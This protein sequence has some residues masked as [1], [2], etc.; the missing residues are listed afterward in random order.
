MNIDN[1]KIHLRI[2]TFNIHNGI[3]WNGKYDPEGIADFIKEVKPDLGGI[4]EVSCWWSPKTRFQNME[5]FFSK[6]LGMYTHFSATIMKSSKGH[7]GNMVISSHPCVNVWTERLPG[8][9][10]P[11]NFIAVQVQ[12]N[13]IRINFLTT[14]LGLTG[15]E[16]L[17]QIEEIIRFGIQ[18]GSPLIITGDFNERESDPGVILL[19]K[20][21][22][23]QSASSRLG[24]I[25]LR[26]NI[27]GPEIDMIF[28]TSDF[29]LES[30]KICPN[31]LSDHLPVIADLTLRTSWT[32]R[33]GT[34]IY[35]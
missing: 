13:G 31:Y 19:K 29:I 11:R 5:K 16:R 25:R 21:W 26:D 27:I 15:A 2:L 22:I 1:R 8:K 32:K 17:P 28:T 7:F 10:E 12:I 23:K 34:P 14:H 4:Q 6:K 35:Q 3:N 30:I 20:Y 24:T 18:L 9:F 33:S